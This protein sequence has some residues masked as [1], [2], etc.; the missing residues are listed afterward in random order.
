[1]LDRRAFVGGVLAVLLTACASVAQDTTTSSA[2]QA[3]NASFTGSVFVWRFGGPS[4]L[5]EAVRIDGSGGLDLSESDV[6]WVEEATPSEVAAVAAGL[7]SLD[8]GA[9]MEAAIDID[10]VPDGELAWNIARFDR[11]LV[12]LDCESQ[13]L[14]AGKCPVLFGGPLDVEVGSIQP[15]GTTAVRR[16]TL[17]VSRTLTAK[18]QRSLGP[19]S[20]D[21]RLRP[22]LAER[23]SFRA[24]GRQVE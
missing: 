18:C 13:R 12:V 20:G 17:K 2:S 1:M 10:D 15:P 23:C 24:D 5:D 21:L 11:D 9:L 3:G 22:V 7:D 14:M 8:W 6:G 19:C 16:W 4:G